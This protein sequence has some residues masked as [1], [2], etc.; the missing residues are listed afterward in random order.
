MKRRSNSNTKTKAA[1]ISAAEKIML[2]EGYPSVTSRRVASE[3]GVKSQIVH[4][5]FRNMEELFIAVYKK[6]TD[7][8]FKRISKII[9]SE[10][11]LEDLWQLLSD[12]DNMILANEFIALANHRKNLVSEMVDAR[13]NIRTILVPILARELDRLQIDQTKWP[14]E[15]IGLAMTLLARGLAVD[16]AFGG[17]SKGHDALRKVISRLF[18]EY[19]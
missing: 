7:K 11:P 4:Y 10:N 8:H 12:P 1:L 2:H 18:S 9:N 15:A 3:A 6:L 16:I 19:G 17:K 5:Y 14:A 13:E